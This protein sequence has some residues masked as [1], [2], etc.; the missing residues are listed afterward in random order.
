MSEFKV[1]AG[2][3][4]T[5]VAL[6]FAWLGFIAGDQ[7]KKHIGPI[8]RLD[9]SGA[10][11]MVWWS[12]ALVY[13]LLAAGTT[14]LVVPRATGGSLSAL[15]WGGLFGLIVYGVFDFTNHAILR[16]YPLQIVILDLAWGVVSCAVVA[17]VAKVIADRGT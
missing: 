6:D 3:L 2:A 11:R 5:A 9:E 10:L 15:L 8:L 16:P 7:F 14:F 1:F 17:A 12:G 4:I 13:V